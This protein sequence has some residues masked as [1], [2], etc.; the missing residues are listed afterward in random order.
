MSGVTEAVAA[1]QRR[2]KAVVDGI[3]D[4]IIADE[5]GTDYAKSWGDGSNAGGPSFGDENPA[6]LTVVPTGDG[7]PKFVRGD[8]NADERINIT[9]G[10]FI[11]DFLFGGATVP[12]REAANANGE[13]DLNITD[14]I[15]LLQFLFGGG[16]PPPAPHPGCG[17]VEG[18]V[19]CASFD[20]CA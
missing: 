20:P 4:R 6:L 17:S 7:G 15:Y 14:G 19:D 16:S 11:L 8:A 1:K 18:D 2:R 12:C 9:D 13:D 3:I 5:D 10:V